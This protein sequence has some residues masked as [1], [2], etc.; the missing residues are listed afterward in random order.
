MVSELDA[1]AIETVATSQHDDNQ[2]VARHPNSVQHATVDGHHLNGLVV[3]ETSPK[4][5]TRRREQS[6]K[7]MIAEILGRRTEHKQSVRSLKSVTR[8][9]HSTV[10]RSTSLAAAKRSSED[11]PTVY[12]SPPA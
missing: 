10:A 7:L 8:E 6:T 11:L 1:K 3:V 12:A 2:G 5:H 9:R 4:R